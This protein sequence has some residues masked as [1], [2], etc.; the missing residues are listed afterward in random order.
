LELGRSHLG[1]AGERD[2]GISG[3]E[4]HGRR[5][6]D[7]SEG[8]IAQRSA[9]D[10]AGICELRCWYLYHEI[11]LSEIV[12]IKIVN[13]IVNIEERASILQS[14]EPLFTKAERE[15]L[16]FFCTYH[17]LWFSP[18][19]LRAAHKQGKFLWGPVNWH[20]RPPSELIKRAE[21]ELESAQTHLKRITLRVADS[22]R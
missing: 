21:E 22:Q 19:E 10:L 9:F 14:L 6:N 13:E 20:L 11:L 16:W 2:D 1:A 4:R 17:D 7:F 5:A 18:A 8:R 15:G 3:P 12:R